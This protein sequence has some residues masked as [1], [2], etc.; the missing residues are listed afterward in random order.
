MLLSDM[1]HQAI[2][3]YRLVSDKTSMRFALKRNLQPHS[4]ST[5]KQWFMHREAASKQQNGGRR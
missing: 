4:G 5:N 1:Y 2:S 3:F